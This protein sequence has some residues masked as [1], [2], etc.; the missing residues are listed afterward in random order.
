MIH[1]LL[2]FTF[3]SL[4]ASSIYLPG[5][6]NAP[7]ADDWAVIQRNLDLSIRDLPM[8]LT[9]PHGGWYRPAFDLFV[10]ACAQFFGFE[11]LGYHIVAFVLY[12]AVAVLVA[13]IIG[14]LT[15]RTDIGALAAALFGVHGAHAEPVLWISASNEL[16]AGVFVLLGLRSYLAFRA[17]SSPGIHYALT[18]VCYLFAIGAKET[19]I[20]LPVALAV[21][22]LLDTSEQTRRERLRRL[23]PVAPLLAIQ[24]VFIAFR[25]WIGSPYPV[26][27]DPFRIAINLA[28]Y[29]AVGLF[30]LPDNYGYLTSLPLWQ[31]QPALPLATLSAAAFALGIMG[32]LFRTSHR[33]IPRRQ[34]RI[35]L[36]A[37][38]WS[39]IALYPVVLTATGRTA[40]MATIGTAWLIAV[41]WGT[42]WKAADRR[43]L[44]CVAALI[45]LIGTHAGVAS[46]RAFWWRQA[47]DEMKRAI[48]W[49]DDALAD[50][51][52]GATACVTGLPDHL[53]HAYVFRN[54]FPTLNQVRFP[55]YVVHAFLDDAQTDE[56]CT[57]AYI[58]PY[59]EE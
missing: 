40:F 43:R 46:Y 56:R 23:T 2:L 4:A 51:P 26:D 1:R 37:A 19:A 10:G 47:G 53:H 6:T 17:S 28:Y 58:I 31:Q 20:F 33:T 27:I 29:L 42:I 54:A 9:A 15:R 13:D 36:F 5:F 30:A 32:W 16:L 11:A 41:L 45:L 14:A 48:V 39:V 3:A 7:L 8:L 34:T 12:L 49:L 21:Y 18:I 59:P 57:G 25:F 52:L 22:D 55:N 50:V 35:L 44:W 38:S 24:G